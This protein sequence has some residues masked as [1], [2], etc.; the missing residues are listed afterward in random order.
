MVLYFCQD[1]H[2]GNMCWMLATSYAHVVCHFEL[3]TPKVD[4]PSSPWFLARL[5]AR[6]LGCLSTMGTSSSV[7]CFGLRLLPSRP[8]RRYLRPSGPV[9]VT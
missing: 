5:D 3:E 6:N 9:L 2:E 7:L 1:H 4:I 8:R